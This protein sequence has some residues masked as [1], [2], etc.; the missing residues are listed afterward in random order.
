MVINEKQS[1][2]KVYSFTLGTNQ[3]QNRTLLI[4][5]KPIAMHVNIGIQSYLPKNCNVLP[6]EKFCSTELS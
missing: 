3:H 2:S 5:L 4:F 6:P 1:I